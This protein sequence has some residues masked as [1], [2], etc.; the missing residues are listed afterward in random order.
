MTITTYERVWVE[1]G[2]MMSEPIDPIEF[3]PVP[4]MTDVLALKDAAMDD[5]IKALGTDIFP[6]LEKESYLNGTITMPERTYN[7]LK[8][9]PKREDYPSR[10]A[11]RKARRDWMKAPNWNV[12]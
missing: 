9:E 11:H 1:G 5:W 8:N 10:Q 6:A 3:M 4:D 2:V 12:R 7:W